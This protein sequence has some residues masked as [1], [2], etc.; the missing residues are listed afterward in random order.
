MLDKSLTTLDQRYSGVPNDRGNSFF[1]FANPTVELVGLCYSVAILVVWASS[2]VFGFV[3]GLGVLTTIG[4]G[5]AV[6]GL[7]RPDIGLI[8]VSTLCVLNP[9]AQFFLTQGGIFRWNTLN[10][11]LLVVMVISLPLL[12]KTRGLQIRLLQ[13]LL[14][15]V[16]IG[17]FYSQNLLSGLDSVLNLITVFGL[18]AYC[19]RAIPYTRCWYWMG[20]ISGSIPAVGGFVY[21]IQLEQLPELN[22]NVWAYFPLTGLFCICLASGAAHQSS[23]K[24]TVLWLLATANS[25][26]VFLTGSRGGML[27]SACCILFL[28]SQIP[29]Q[30][31]R[32]LCISVFVFLGV[33]AVVQ[34][35]DRWRFAVDRAQL[36]VDRDESVARRTSGRSDLYVAG[37][38]M[39]LEHPVA[40]IGTGSFQT[41]WG[42]L[43]NTEGLRL[44]TRRPKS[45]HSGWVK[46]LA[47]NGV[48]GIIVFACFIG[49]FACLG[50]QQ[51][52][53][54]H[55]S[56]GVT[57][58]LLLCIAFLSEEF[59]RRGLMLLAAG[60]I[61]ILNSSSKTTT[62]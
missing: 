16:T 19:F 14:I 18:L 8:G 31:H 50:W 23:Q 5:A 41:A 28:L 26:W 60:G 29:G 54:G 30:K 53:A 21:F 11:W 56:F 44:S 49:T 55:F 58:S 45:A 22:P 48:L 10:Y 3:F 47:E 20:I 32:L 33:I 15:V 6:F 24:C 1:R 9:P 40:G 35:P 51:F 46:I 12:L 27:I 38:R 7:T 43:A 52:S 17:L 36:L 34:F 37:V 13:T 2:L 61:A 42:Q 25:G 4:F 57:V 39:F 62:P 59:G